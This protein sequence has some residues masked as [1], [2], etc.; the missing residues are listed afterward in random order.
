MTVG[1]HADDDILNHFRLPFEDNCNVAFEVCNGSVQE[2]ECVGICVFLIR[3]GI[4]GIVEDHHDA[5]DLDDVEML[6]LFFADRLGIDECPV[7]AV[8]V[9]REHISRSSGDAQMTPRDIAVVDLNVAFGVASDDDIVAVEHEFPS[10]PV[11]FL[12]GQS[13][14]IP[15]LRI[16][17]RQFLSFDDFYFF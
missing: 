16:H 13:R 4:V 3:S 2:F 11:S 6:D 15:S 17:Y 14:L 5:S 1:E 9:F 12:N 7:C 10:G 8:E